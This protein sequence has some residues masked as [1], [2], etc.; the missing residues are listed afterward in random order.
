[1]T[2]G[3]F[4]K[5]T[6]FWRLPL[7]G[8]WRRPVM[9]S[10][11][12]LSCLW[13]AVPATAKPATPH[14][15][16]GERLQTLNRQILADRDR[17]SGI[18]ERYLGTDE[19]SE[20]DFNWLKITAE[21]YGL[22]PRQRGDQRFF[23]ALLDRIDVVPP[24]LALALGWLEYGWRPRSDNRLPTACLGSCRKWRPGL[25]V[26]APE[27]MHAWVHQLNTDPRYAPFRA[28][29][30]EL[31]RLQRPLSAGNLAPALEPLTSEGKAYT[32]RLQTITR[33]LRLDR[34]DSTAR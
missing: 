15:A 2:S 14:A 5:T 26:P 24:S 34:W 32:R 16:M 11:L 10:L 30:S 7:N 13:I 3:E 25:A 33:Q 20:E 4:M 22:E 21:K 18:A 8:Y 31:R 17:A 29:R 28:R 27:D 23:T 1:M 19:I 6:S 9:A 12:F